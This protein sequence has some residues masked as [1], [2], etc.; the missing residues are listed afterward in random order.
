MFYSFWEKPIIH[1]LLSGGLVFTLSHEDLL[2]WDKFRIRVVSRQRSSLSLTLHTYLGQQITWCLYGS[3]QQKKLFVKCC[4]HTTLWECS[5]AVRRLHTPSAHQLHLGSS[6]DSA[7]NSVYLNHRHQD[8]TIDCSCFN[9]K[10]YENDSSEDLYQTK[11]FYY[12]YAICT[13]QQHLIVNGIPWDLATAV[14]L[15]DQPSQLT[16]QIP[17]QRVQLEASEVGRGEARSIS[18]RAGSGGRRQ[19]DGARVYGKKA[20]EDG[21]QNKH[22]HQEDEEGS[23]GV[24][25]S[26]HHA[27]QQTD[28]GDRCGVQQRPPVAWWKNLV[29]RSGQCRI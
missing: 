10:T 24:D 17:E 22:D 18:R 6:S 14:L 23:L 25:V 21:A 19:G 4:R 9:W 12:V 3:Y 1:L 29:G 16:P 20:D 26:T 28:Q 27:H 13:A 7:I 15:L 5:P 2:T 11:V 8:W